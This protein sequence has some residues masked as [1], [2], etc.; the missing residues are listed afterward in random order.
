MVVAQEKLRYEQPAEGLPKSGR[1]VKRKTRKVN[2]FRRAK[3]LALSLV[4]LGFASGVF[5]AAQYAKLAIKNYQV[6]ELQKA[7]SAKQAEKQQL[8]LQI[9]Q[10]KSVG[11]IESIA[12]NQLGM[13]KPAKYGILDYQDGQQPKKPTTVGAVTPDAP[14]AAAQESQGNPVIRQVAQI[15]T[16]IFG[17]QGR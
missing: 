7:I 4:V 5:I 15:L 17:S 14:A 8:Q 9:S 13:V 16:N 12:V 1:V 3:I 10:L 2:K 11:R 6:A